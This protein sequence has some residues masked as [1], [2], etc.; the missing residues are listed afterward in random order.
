MCVCVY[1]CTHFQILIS[2]H[3]LKQDTVNAILV[4]QE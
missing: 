4:L 3:H 1:V 2:V